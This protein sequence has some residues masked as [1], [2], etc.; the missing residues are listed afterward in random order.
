MFVCHLSIKGFRGIE[1]AEIVLM[2]H[3]ILLGTNNVGKSTIVDA[4]GLVLGRDRLVRQLGDYD[5]YGGLPQPDSRI[6]I[7][8]TVTGFTPDELDYHFDWFNTEDGATHMWWDGKQVTSGDRPENGKLCAQIAFVARFDEEDLEV[9]TIRYFLDGDGD[10]F[11]QNV[12]KVRTRH[13]KQLGF[14]LLPSQRTWDRI[15]SF[16]SELFRR[17]LR[18]QK[19]IPSSSVTGLRDVLRNPSV[20]L[21]DDPEITDFVKRLNQEIDGFIGNESSGL[22]FRPTSGDIE[23]ILQAMTPHLPGKADT[24]LPLSRHGSGVISLQTLLLLFEFGRARSKDNQNFIL[25]AEEPELHLH[26]GHHSRLVARIC[27]TSD[28]SITTT[29]SPEIAAYYGPTEILIV[30]NHNG[31]MDAIPLVAHDDKIPDQ[32]ALMQLYTLHRAAICEA[33]MHHCVLVPEGKTE[34]QWFRSM[35]RLRITLGGWET[36]PKN[37]SIGIIP[38]TDSHVVQIFEKFEP[39]VPRVVP[40][41]DGDGAGD[42]YRKKLLKTGTPPSVVIQL[43]KD[44]MLEDVVCWLLAASSAEDWKE[45]DA[46]LPDVTVTDIASLS[47]ALTKFKT[48]WKVHEEILAYISTNEES[49]NRLCQFCDGLSDV[50]L[51]GETEQEC[52]IEDPD[53]SEGAATRIWRWTNQKGG[54]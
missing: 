33:L 50:A 21:E 51:T 52:W 29:H 45:I 6:R 49:K 36:A 28:Q 16:A 42:G 7:V 40:V 37:E 4:L 11:E 9:E 12:H 22:Q 2:E 35:M 5:F 23:G 38:T 30:R 19:A 14:F 13:L 15:V 39:L 53:S 31:Q 41:V 20:K 3:S 44:L 47:A 8:A 54:T 25:A 43:E 32:N 17:V 27:G 34:F 46:L 10:P 1:R 48:F 26:P 24:V 18:F